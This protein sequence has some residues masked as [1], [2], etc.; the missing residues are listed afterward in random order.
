MLSDGRRDERPSDLRLKPHGFIGPK[1]FRHANVAEIRRDP[2]AV[3]KGEHSRPQSVSASFGL[4]PAPVGDETAEGS[5]KFV[6]RF[7]TVSSSSRD[8][9]YSG[10]SRSDAAGTTRRQ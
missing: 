5:V 10:L 9:P 6:S 7:P 3:A 1:R 2:H 4:S 8:I